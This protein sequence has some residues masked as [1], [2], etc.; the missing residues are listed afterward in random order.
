M[1]P[2]ELILRYFDKALMGLAGLWLLLSLGGFFSRPAE[3]SQRDEL[4]RDIEKIESYRRSHRAGASALP[5]WER[6]VEEQ[7]MASQVPTTESLPN[8]VLHNRPNVLFRFDV[9]P[10]KPV[11]AHFAAQDLSVRPDRGVI[12]VSW[13]HNNENALVRVKDYE[14][15]RQECGQGEFVSIGKVDGSVLE[16]E[17]RSVKPRRDYAYR[18]VSEAELDRDHPLVSPMLIR[19]PKLELDEKERQKASE[20]SNFVRQPRIVIV[21]PESVTE[22]SHEERLEALRKNEMEPYKATLKIY[23]WDELNPQKWSRAVFYNKTI[24]D[25][26]KEEKVIDKRKV[27]F[28]AGTLIKVSLK[29]V[30]D[31]RQPSLTMRVLKVTMR[32]E[33]GSVAE[34]SNIDENKEIEGIK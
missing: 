29:Q 12:T 17:D 32:F 34:Y 25:T 26:I 23:V 13:K 16:Y 15:Q 33:D 27:W 24:N 11:I 9:P 21:V 7:L 14:I 4:V 20:A 5:N 19:E 1:D 30:Q 22:P 18:V 10:E 8:W 6:E 28:D 31:P 3:L 2:K